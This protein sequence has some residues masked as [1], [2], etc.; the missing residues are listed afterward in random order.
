MGSCRSEGVGLYRRRAWA[1][2]FTIG[3]TSSLI[4]LELYEINREVRLLRGVILGL[5]AAVV[6]YLFKRKDV[7]V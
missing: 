2:W 3:A 6:I 5:N 4:P 1:R 7:F